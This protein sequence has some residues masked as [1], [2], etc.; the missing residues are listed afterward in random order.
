MT[1][2]SAARSLL[3]EVEQ[4]DS[5]SLPRLG[6]RLYQLEHGSGALASDQPSQAEWRQIWQAY[7]ARRP[8]P[9]A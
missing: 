9:P 1:L 5:R 6:A 8:T 3:T 4:A 2:G 7:R